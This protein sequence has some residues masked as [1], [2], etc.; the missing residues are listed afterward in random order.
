M[1]QSD[2]QPSETLLKTALDEIRAT[3]AKYES[4]YFDGEDKDFLIISMKQIRDRLFDL[5]MDHFGRYMNE[6]GQIDNLSAEKNKIFEEIKSLKERIDRFIMGDF[7][8]D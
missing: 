8:F 1:N 7:D 3:M 4:K 5:Q 2:Q 6:K